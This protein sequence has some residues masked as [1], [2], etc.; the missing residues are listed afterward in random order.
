MKPA[1]R[2]LI[3]YVSLGLNVALIGL[4][5]VH[6]YLTSNPANTTLPLPP[7]GPDMPPFPPHFDTVAKKLE[8]TDDQRS[9]V[10][11]VFENGRDEAL[12]H[13]NELREAR[14]RLVRFII[15]NPEDADGLTKIIEA[16]ADFPRRMATMM[17]GHLREVVQILTPE[18][19]IKL[20]AQFEE[21]ERGHGPVML[22][23]E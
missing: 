18:Q 19:R 1:L 17:A 9:R 20:L 2:E 6:P 13:F 5:A 16:D 23:A 14:L 3:L 4:V 11:A 7:I 12:G 8:L 10:V 21:L 15:E 22:E